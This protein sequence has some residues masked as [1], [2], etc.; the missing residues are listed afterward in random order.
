MGFLG[1]SEWLHIN[2]K[3][4][5]FGKDKNTE[6]DEYYRPAFKPSDQYKP[7]YKG[8][9]STKDIILY[10]RSKKGERKEK[11]P[12]PKNSQEAFEFINGKKEFIYLEQN[13]INH[14]KEDA[15]EV[16]FISET[17]QITFNKLFIE[18]ISE[19]D[20]LKKGNIAKR[21]NSTNDSD[22]EKYLFNRNKML[23]E[24]NT[25][26]SQGAHL[27]GIEKVRGEYY[28]DIDRKKFRYG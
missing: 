22:L 14:Y 18:S 5:D 1:N 3:L 6:R 17:G 7:K 10:M 16:E 4:I 26:F 20:Y 21:G 9:N 19:L 27:Q 8:N 13:M 15:E 23:Y 25:G 28:F 11:N 2:N 24:D 12:P